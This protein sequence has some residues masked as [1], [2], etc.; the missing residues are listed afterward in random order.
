MGGE[1]VNSRHRDGIGRQVE[2][3]MPHPQGLPGWVGK[4]KVGNE[5]ESPE[6][7]G[8]PG[9]GKGICCCVVVVVVVVLLLLLL[10]Q[11]LQSPEAPACTGRMIET[12]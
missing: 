1:S 6:A 2:Q 7:D 12:E 11:A 3:Q 5:R 9:R 4:I 10:R 8:L